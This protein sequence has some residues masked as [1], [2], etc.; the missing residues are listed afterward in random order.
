MSV[1]N[2]KIKRPVIDY[3]L[4]TGTV[5][6][7]TGD[8]RHDR[9]HWDSDGMVDLLIDE[10]NLDNYYI[11]FEINRITGNLPQDYYQSNQNIWK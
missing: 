5:I 8:A 2:V 7:L 11:D 4:P 10:N 1:N 3:M 9:K 6:T